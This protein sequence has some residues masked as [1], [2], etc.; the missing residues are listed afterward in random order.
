MDFAAGVYLSEAQPKPSSPLHIV[1]VYTLYST[2]YWFTQGRGKR[3]E[4]ERKKERGNRGEYRSQS[5]V[6]NTN[7][8]ECKQKLAISSL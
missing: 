1:Y 7:M 8:I 2:V 4:P 5:L 3:V 6:E